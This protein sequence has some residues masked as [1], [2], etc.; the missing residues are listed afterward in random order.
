MIIK[1]NSQTIFL[2][3]GI[4][5]VLHLFK[6]QKKSSKNDYSWIFEGYCDK[7]DQ[8]GNDAI[9]QILDNYKGGGFMLSKWG[10]I[11]LD[12]VLSTYLIHEVG[13]YHLKML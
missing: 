10:T 6:I 11:E 3:K 2:L 12:Q 13:G 4:R 7:K 1:I 5:K 8:D 9:L